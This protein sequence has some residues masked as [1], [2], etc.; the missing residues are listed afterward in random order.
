MKYDVAVVGGGPGGYYAAIRAAQ[1][2][3]KTILFEQKRIGGTC[4]NV[5]CIPTKCLLD[6]AELISKIREYTEIGI[7]RDAGVFSWSRMMRFKDD[8]VGK[9]TDGVEGILKSYGVKI[10]GQ[11]AIVEK[12]GFV[13][14]PD[15]GE[16]FESKN[17][18]LATGSKVVDPPI[19]G[20]DGVNVIDSTGA[21]SLK[22]LP[23]DMVII[24]G[25]VI[26]LEFASLYETMGC[27]V[28]VL[29]MLEEI[30]PAEDRDGIQLVVR[31]LEKQGVGILTGAK[32]RRISDSNGVKTVA[33]SR[34][35]SESSVSAEYVV[36]AVGR[37]ASRDGIDDKALG[38]K[39]DP[40]GNIEVDQRM[41]TNVKG[42][43]AV[44][45]VAGGYQ[46]AHAAY[47]EAETAA[48]NCAGI[49]AEVDES[50]M[51][52]CL[53]TLPQYAGVGL[54]EQQLRDRKIDY[55]VGRFPYAANGKALAQNEK[56]GFSKVLAD[57]ATGRIL[58]AFLVG[59]NATELLSAMITAMNGGMDI[60]TVGKSI[61]P[62]PTMSEMWKECVEAVCSACVHLPKKC[63]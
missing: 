8:T 9:L 33:Y 45:D 34:G 62:H 11:R 61:Y 20:I 13:N 52:R 49:D 56:E 3:L 57:A 7:L 6:K 4:L 63:D 59:H 40:K 46:L 24:G 58:G 14:C 48:K 47:A 23:K 37:S 29:E 41:Q 30:L 12:A 44:G 5:G 10:I 60:L 55:R 42:L 26:G 16:A 54:T 22:R 31:H 51:P 15:T 17:I 1:L 39:L 50:I 28:T 19:Q 18:I 43:Y 32:V 2:G 27:Q 38:L 53:Y 25:G 35:G 36:K 21:L